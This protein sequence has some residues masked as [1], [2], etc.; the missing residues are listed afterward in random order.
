MLDS[1][2]NLA[3]LV[4]GEMPPDTSKARTKVLGKRVV[5]GWEWNPLL[6]Y[7]PNLQC[8]CGK[9]ILK[10]KRCCLPKLKPAVPVKYANMFKQYMKEIKHD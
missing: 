10:A 6:K 8:F 3:M 7:P 5:E 4:G 2:F 1:L 9:T